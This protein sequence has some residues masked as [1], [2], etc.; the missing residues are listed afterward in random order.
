MSLERFHFEVHHLNWIVSHGGVEGQ[1]FT[2]LSHGAD[3]VISTKVGPALPEWIHDGGLRVLVYSAILVG[4]FDVVRWN[5]QV[6]S[7]LDERSMRVSPG[8]MYDS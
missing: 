7:Q 1:N 8:P 5:G 2:C 6:E 3:P 4:V